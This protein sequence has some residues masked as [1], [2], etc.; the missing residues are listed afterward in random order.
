M[1]TI[2]ID[3]FSG[4]FIESTAGRTKKSFLLLSILA[5]GG[6]LFF[7]K[8]FNFFNENLSAISGFFNIAYQPFILNIVLP[9]GLSFHVFQSMSY[10]IE[11]YRGNQKAERHFGILALYV[12]FFPQLVAGPIERP[13]NLIHQFYERHKFDISRVGSGLALMLGGFIKKV[14]IADRLALFVNPVFSNATEYYGISLLIAGVFFAFQIYCDFSGYS[15]IA[16]GSA[17][18]LGINLMQ[19]FERPFFARSIAKFW[20]RWHIS[21]SSWLHDYLYYPIVFSFKQKTAAKLYLA[22][23]ITFT[24]IGL[25]HGANWTFVIFGALQGIYIF[26]GQATKQ[27]RTRIAEWVGIAKWPSLYHIWQSAI[28]FGLFSLSLIFFRANTLQDAVYII[29]HFGDGWPVFISNFSNPQFLNQYIFM[30]FSKSEFYLSVFSILSL[31]SYELIYKTTK[32]R[33][34]FDRQPAF[35]GAFIFT[36]GILSLFVFGTFS[37]QEFIY[38]QF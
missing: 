30:G 22:T 3:Y 29:S 19:N 37:G 34:F 27:F 32:F 5:N 24:L 10:T 23:L 31:I 4:I 13:Q 21:L 18:V 35:V 26:I 9:I 33:A 38:F 28:V 11:I 6:M 7:F 12:L 36:L 8:Y 20:Q 2:I 1:T 25:W 16:L 15:S 17:R 14:V